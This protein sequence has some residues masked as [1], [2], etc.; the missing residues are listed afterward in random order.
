M[1]LL[2]TPPRNAV[3][4][5]CQWVSLL[6]CPDCQAFAVPL[7]YFGRFLSE[8]KLQY[9]QVL[10]SLPS[11]VDVEVAGIEPASKQF[12]IV[13]TKFVV[14]KQSP[15]VIPFFCSPSVFFTIVMNPFHFDCRNCLSVFNCTMREKLLNPVQD[16]DLRYFCYY[17]ANQSIQLFAS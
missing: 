14:W 12:Q 16:S 13:S 1:F 4:V 5:P 7:C 6:I 3:S 9:Q 8:Q 11:F 15:A 2:H 10:L 17:R